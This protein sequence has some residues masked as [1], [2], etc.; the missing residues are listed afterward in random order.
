MK[1]QTVN[2]QVLFYIPDALWEDFLLSV[3]PLHNVALM[4]VINKN[5]IAI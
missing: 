1:I 5:N 3:L 2:K 4:E